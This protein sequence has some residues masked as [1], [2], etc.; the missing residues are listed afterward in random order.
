MWI[1]P[2][3]ERRVRAP[4]SGE[5]AS[6]PLREGPKAV[7]GAGPAPLKRAATNRLTNV[8]EGQ[9]SA[10]GNKRRAYENAHVAREMLGCLDCA[11]AWGCAPEDSQARVTLDRLLAVCWGLTH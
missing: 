10:G 5:S 3:R 8:A 6:P 1:T 4:P 2:A 11:M 7:W 9:R